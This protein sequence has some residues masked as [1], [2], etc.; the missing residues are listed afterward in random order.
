MGEF[1]LENQRIQAFLSSEP[2]VRSCGVL[3]TYQQLLIDNK[4]NSAKCGDIKRRLYEVF[5]QKNGGGKI[6]DK[7]RKKLS[8]EFGQIREQ[9]YDLCESGKFTK[10]KMAELYA[11]SSISD[12]LLEQWNPKAGTINPNGHFI[13]NEAMEYVND[14]PENKD[15]DINI[16]PTSVK[17]TGELLSKVL[18][19]LQ[20][21]A[22]EMKNGSLM[23]A[24]QV[25]MTSWLFGAS[26]ENKFKV[27]FGEN[28][29]LEDVSGEIVN[30]I[31]TLAL[32]YNRRVM[33][34][35]LTT[36]QLPPVRRLIMPKDDFIS[37]F[38]V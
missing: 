21:V 12:K 5:D 34:E 19:G 35:Y 28:I 24:D 30:E 37:R 29:V 8:H 31:Q 33:A 26:F 27:I 16:L 9:V 14:G 10:E 15:V 2:F 3:E 38:S 4:D 1:G 36:G 17:G 22:K 11:K 23:H 7:S 13:V 20:K 25:V 18:E 32:S 6:K